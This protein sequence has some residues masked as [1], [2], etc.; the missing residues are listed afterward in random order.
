LAISL[1]AGLAFI[2]LAGK[3][4]EKIPYPAATLIVASN[5]KAR[6]RWA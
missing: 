3:A 5:T 1:D 2:L 6:L 4:S